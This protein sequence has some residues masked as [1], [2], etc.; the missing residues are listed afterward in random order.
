MR[1]ATLV[2]DN[3][4][5]IRL[6]EEQ[7]RQI[8]NHPKARRLRARCQQ[9]TLKIHQLGFTVKEAQHGEL[10]LR[11]DEEEDTKAKRLC[12]EALELGRQK[13]EADAELNR[14]LTKLRESALEKN[15]KRHF[16]NTD[17]EIFNRQYEAQPCD[18]ES[19]QRNI[20]PN[21]SI[22]EREEVVRLLCY[23]PAPQTDEEAH[24]RRLDFIRLLVRWQRRKESPRRGKQASAVISHPEWGTTTR[25]TAPAAISEKYDA[26]QCPFCLSDRSLPPIDRERKKSK[27]NKLWDHVE[28]M[29]KLELAVFDD[30]TKPCGLCGMRKVHF[31]PPSVTHFK[32]HT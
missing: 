6:T 30:G 18:E 28:N 4:A 26:L 9:L 23:S 1:T 29:H 16:R 7:S 14:T 31:V 11:L 10:E 25:E 20:Q 27:R 3:T 19:E 8:S 24:L 2:A 21:Y 12:E 22:P 5:P 13:K 17:T 15:R 32:N